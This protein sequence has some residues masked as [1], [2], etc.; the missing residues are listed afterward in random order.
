MPILQQQIPNNVVLAFGSRVTGTSKPFSDLDL[1]ILGDEP[2]PAVVLSNL[3]EA[4]D[5]SDLP[6]KV[7]IVDWATTNESFRKIIERQ[8]LRILP[9]PASR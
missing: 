1:A 5:D 7:D 4:F 6:F 8:A 9:K 2:L 3:G